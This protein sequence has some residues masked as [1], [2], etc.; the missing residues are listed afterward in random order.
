[1]WNRRRI[2]R[3]R[4]GSFALRLPSEERELLRQLPD[5][6]R[7]L[8][9]GARRGLT[10]WERLRGLL[11]LRSLTRPVSPAGGTAS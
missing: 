8:L 6:L 1:M 10:T 3:A 7:A 9:E 11:S 2:E 5:Q 4:D